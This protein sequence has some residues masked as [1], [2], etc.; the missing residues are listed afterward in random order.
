M[1][2]QELKD[3]YTM[4][5]DYMASSKNPS[6]MMTFGKVMNEMM[7]WMIQNKPDLAQDMIEK[8]CA[9]KWHNYLTPKEAEKIVANMHPKA[10]WSR[11][12]WKNAMV[13][14]DLPL[15]DE[16]YYN[17]CALWTTMNM[18]YSDSSESIA[19][20]IGKPLAEIPAE[21]MVKAV[22][23]LAVDKLTDEDGM[24]KIRKYFDI[25]L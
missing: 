20:I 12:V 16:P 22:Y 14:F 5:Y 3:K 2:A 6:Y 23:T 9:I 24:F 18:V 1:N 17:T 21:Q 15:E 19:D 10:P 7:D 13:S 8:L 25:Y 4:L 11:D